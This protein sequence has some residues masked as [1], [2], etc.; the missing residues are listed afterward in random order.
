MHVL[1]VLPALN[2]G[3]V[4]R[5]TLEIADALV[6]AGHRATVLSAGGRMVAPLTQLG[7]AHITLD[8]GAKSPLTLTKLPSLRRLLAGGDFDI[9]HVRSRLPAWMVWLAWRSL[10]KRRRPRLVSTVH[11]LN[12]PSAYS[13]IMLCGERVIVVSDTVR[14][15]VLE[16][17]PETNPGKLVLIPRGIDPDQFPH[18][19]QTSADWRERFVA[20]YPSLAGPAPWL[21]LPGRGTRLKGHETALHLLANLIKQG[22][23]ARLI[24][25]GAQQD[26]RDHYTEQLV[27]T[28]TAL[29][30]GAK[31]VMTPPRPDV[32]D[33]FAA[34]HAVLQLSTKPEA[35]GRTVVEALQLGVPVV[36]FDHGGAGELLRELFPVGLVAHDDPEALGNVTLQVV[37]NRP[38]VPAFSR[39]RLADM[40][41]ATLTVYRDLLCTA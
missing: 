37:Q 9:V 21:C 26:G 38:I 22:Q 28:A 27:A 7:A 34:S 18:G 15:Y 40:Q 32:R 31:V 1:Q 33:V 6:R 3:G 14:R 13:R 23:D 24:M 5:G 20:A 39:Y 36:G 19:Y 10:P 35:F 2:A 4:E 12:S 41:A 30:I 8:L 17:Y 29:G 25:L 16:H 11:G